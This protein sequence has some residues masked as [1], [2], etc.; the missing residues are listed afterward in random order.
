MP[1]LE[2]MRRRLA[3]FLSGKPRVEWVDPCR[4]CRQ[5][6]GEIDGLCS[7]CSIFVAVRK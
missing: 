3:S 6:P 2:Q 4:S 5:R 7:W 1:D